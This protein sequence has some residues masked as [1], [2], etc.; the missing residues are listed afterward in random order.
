MAT[1]E[2]KVSDIFHDQTDLMKHFHELIPK[3]FNESERSFKKRMRRYKDDNM[4]A[5]PTLL[6]DIAFIDYFYEELDDWFLSWVIDHYAHEFTTD[7]LEEMASQAHSHLDFYEVIRP[8]PG[9][10][11]KVQSLF[12]EKSIFV[13]DINSSYMFTKWDIFLARCYPWKGQ[14]YVTGLAHL[15]S[16]QNRTFIIDRLNEEFTKYRTAYGDDDYSHFAKDRWDIFFQIKHEISKQNENKKIYTA[17]GEFAPKDVIFNVNDLKSVL[18]KI[19]DLNEFE[20]TEQIE[21]RDRKNKQ[22]YMPQFQFDWLTSGHEHEIDKMRLTNQKGILSSIQQLDE[23]G[24][25]T[26]IEYLG[27]L[28]VDPYLARLTVNSLELAEYAKA[29]LPQLFDNQIAFKRL[30]KS[31][32]PQKEKSQSQSEPEPIDDELKAKIQ[33][34]IEQ[35]YMVNILDEKIPML[36]NKTPREARQD[37]DT[38]PLLIQWLKEFENLELRK[39]R[40][41]AISM[42]VEKLKNELDIKF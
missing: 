40:D 17:F 29:R 5:D 9:E 32:T 25:Q 28:A 26:G 8:Q 3:I 34:Q 33:E 21:K 38:L 7:E 36:N 20:F 19:K 35:E 12:T 18:N 16:P 23:N 30:I 4:P 41:N 13:K 1:F 39:K 24:H 31:Q 22:K 6:Y 15:F 10:G 2:K 42:D 37:P 11:S 14:H 27:N